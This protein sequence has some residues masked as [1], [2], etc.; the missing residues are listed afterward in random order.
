MNTIVKY[1]LS[2]VTAVS[3]FNSLQLHLKSGI[4]SNIN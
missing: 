4:D 3:L 1:G 2:H